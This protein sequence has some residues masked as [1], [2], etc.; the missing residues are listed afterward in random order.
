MVLT[1]DIKSPIAVLWHCTLNMSHFASTAG[2]TRRVL[3]RCHAIVE[4]R[5]FCVAHY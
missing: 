3:C 1:Y 4:G 5:S 2:G